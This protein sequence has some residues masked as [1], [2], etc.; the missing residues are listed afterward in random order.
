MLR[1]RRRPDRVGSHTTGRELTPG[2][3]RD[4]LR[5]G[6]RSWV[7]QAR[8]VRDRARTDRRRAH[9]RA[10]GLPGRARR[11]AL[12]R[13]QP[14]AASGRAPV[15][16]QH[17][18]A[19]AA[20]RR[21]SRGRGHARD[22]G[23]MGHDAGPH[24]TRGA[25]VG[26]LV[27]SGGSLYVSID[28]DVLDLSLVPG[29][30]LPEP[31]GLSYR[32]LRSVLAEVGRRA[33]VRAF[34]IAELNPPF[35]ASGSTARLASWTALPRRDLR[36]ADLSLRAFRRRSRGGAASS[37]AAGSGRCSRS[38]SAGGSPG[39]RARPPRTGRPR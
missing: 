7:V 1:A 10:R 5:P 24:R 19:R 9:R 11:R 4:R 14:A 34:D 26:E 3:P 28:L 17:H 30:T 12:H 27:P 2:P 32:E 13:R 38:G 15:R 33:P 16:A 35:D 39:A 6:A 31:G 18:S 37:P 23:A 21:P 20:Q 22:G 25:V 29:T 8:D 36:P